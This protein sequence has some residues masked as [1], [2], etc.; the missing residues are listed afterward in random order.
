MPRASRHR[1]WVFTLNNPPPAEGFLELLESSGILKY[2]VFQLERG[3]DAGT[4]HFQGYFICTQPRSLTFIRAQLTPRAHFEVR[5]GTHEQAKEYCTKEDT[6]VAGPFTF[7]EEPAGQ[8]SRTDLSA[9]KVILDN[10]GGLPAVAREH[11]GSFCRYYRAFERYL[12]LITP[13]RSEPTK[14]IV[15]YG[16]SGSGKSRSVAEAAGPD[17]YWLPKPNGTR[18]FWDGYEGQEAVVIDE[19]YGWLP[20][21][22]LLRLLDRYPLRVETKGGSV[23]FTSK[24]VYFTSNQSPS[25]WYRNGLRSLKRRLLA[26]LGNVY[27]LDHLGQVPILVTEFEEPAVG[28]VHLPF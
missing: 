16:E 3:A 27:R 11:F 22:F 25:R 23:A 8:G 6:R 13:Q 18:A 19:F 12:L 1:N 17:A 14:A 20:Y 2:C 7:G 28:G 4:Q 24:V 5:R 21:N 10:G 26:P 15:Y 9:V